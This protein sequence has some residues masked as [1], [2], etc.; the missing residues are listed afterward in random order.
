MPKID[1]KFKLTGKQLAA[2]HGYNLYAAISRLLPQLHEYSEF[3][4]HPI[5]GHL[6]GNRLLQL[7][8]YSYLTVRVPIESIS[9]VIPLA[10]KIL[11]IGEHEIQV[12]VPNASALIPSKHLYSRLVVIKGFMEPDDFLSAVMRQVNELSIIAEPSL[13]EQPNIQNS[14]KGK[15]AGTRSPYLRRTIGIKNKEIVGFA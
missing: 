15:E 3:G 4:I 9:Q 7:T 13:I 5:A 12:G 11:N 10:G 2:D 14:N 1:V 6:I 8:D